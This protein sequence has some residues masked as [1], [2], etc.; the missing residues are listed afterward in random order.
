MVKY[1]LESAEYFWPKNL[2]DF[3]V[4]T[5]HG[6]EWIEQFL[7]PHVKVFYETYPPGVNGRLGMSALSFFN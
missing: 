4:I 1:L 3:I 6:A 5:D 7:P 2:G